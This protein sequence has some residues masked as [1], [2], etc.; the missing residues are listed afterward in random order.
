MFMHSDSCIANK[1]LVY[2][3]VN[4]DAVF[5]VKDMHGFIVPVL[6]YGRCVEE[7]TNIAA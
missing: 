7:T 1:V 3:R 2:R 6:L 5:N 4:S